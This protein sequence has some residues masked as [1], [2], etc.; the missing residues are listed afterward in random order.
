MKNVCAS[1]QIHDWSHTPIAVETDRLEDPVA[2][3]RSAHHALTQ[4][5]VDIQSTIDRA[6]MGGAEVRE[7]LARPAVRQ[8]LQAGLAASRE[9]R[10]ASALLTL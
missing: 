2:R 9:L 5:R 1:A 8:A 3:R 4:L 10:V 7:I 6:A